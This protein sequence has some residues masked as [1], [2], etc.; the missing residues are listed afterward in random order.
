MTTWTIRPGRE[1]QRLVRPGDP[2]AALRC[3][4]ACSRYL[5]ILDAE[6]ERVR[7]LFS[8]ET[9]VTM[10]NAVRDFKPLVLRVVF[11]SQAREWFEGILRNACAT[12]EICEE[13]VD[14]ICEEVV[15]LTDLEFFVML[16]LVEQDA[17]TERRA[18]PP[19]G[20]E[21]VASRG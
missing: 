15:V 1:L 2:S 4:E 16:E 17:L 12:N 19:R 21:A 7:A 11:A 20:G 18:M 8:D 5:A 3:T 13:V 9:W 14:E 6:G 10:V